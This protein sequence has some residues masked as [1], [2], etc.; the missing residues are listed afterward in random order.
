MP[1]IEGIIEILSA[2]YGPQGWWPLLRQDPLTR[3]WQE[4]YHPGD[5]RPPTSQETRFEIGA[6]AILTQ[7][8]SWQGALTALISLKQSGCL[9]PRRLAEEPDIETLCRLIRSSGF[10]NQKQERLRLW[11]RFILSLKERTP[12]RAELLALKGIGPETADS[13]LLY[14]YGQPVFI[15]DA[16]ARLLITRLLGG[17]WTYENLAGEMNHLF[18]HLNEP[19]RLKMFNEAHALFVY[20]GKQHCGK[21]LRCQG[22]IL[23]STCSFFSGARHFF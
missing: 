8:T 16:Y 5:Y 3:T 7:N 12:A 6:G 9:E 14:A 1:T 10:F 13:I 11:A 17:T 19:D 23:R 4:T 2:H 20:H 22:C 15:A 21:R 18:R